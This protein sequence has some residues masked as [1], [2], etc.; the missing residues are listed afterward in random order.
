M[1]PITVSI[2]MTLL[3]PWITKGLAYIL[4]PAMVQPTANA[5]MDAAKTKA[6]FTSRVD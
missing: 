3:S 4:P 2:A 1:D 6:G 5:I